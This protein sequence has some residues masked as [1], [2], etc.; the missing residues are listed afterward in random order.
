[1]ESESKT[2]R[3]RESEIRRQTETGRVRLGDR[4]KHG[5]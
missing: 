1:M 4:Q 3:N 5:E 2:E